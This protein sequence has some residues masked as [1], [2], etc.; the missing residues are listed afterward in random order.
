MTIT[1]SAEQ[2]RLI[3]Q[4]MQAGGYEKADDVIAPA[5]QVLRVEDEPLREHQS[6]VAGKIDR[7][8]EQFARGAFFTADEARAD[9]A[10]RKAAPETGRHPAR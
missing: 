3:P 7:A 4:A 1:L 5:L 10:R 8:L 9:M 2:E 6:E